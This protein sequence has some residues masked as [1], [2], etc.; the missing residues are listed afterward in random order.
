MDVTQVRLENIRLLMERRAALVGPASAPASAAGAL[1]QVRSAKKK[2]SDAGARAIE[3]LLGLPP[4]WLD[5]PRASSED[6]ADL[7]PSW[8]DELAAD[9]RT[10]VLQFVASTR[11]VLSDDETRLLQ[12]FRAASPESREVI[13]AVATAQ[14]R[15]RAG[16]F[17][18]YVGTL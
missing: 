4:E 15:Q 6:L 11:K 17:G 14:V 13:L 3:R 18:Y 1:L 7:S 5:Q 2:L 9:A 12:A 16:T 8:W 10:M